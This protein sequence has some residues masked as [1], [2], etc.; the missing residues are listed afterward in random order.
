MAFAIVVGTIVARAV[1]PRRRMR[2]RM[3]RRAR[4]LLSEHPDAE[5][6]SQYMRFESTFE[7]GKLRELDVLIS[8][9]NKE[10]WTYVRIRGASPLLTL[11]SWGGGV[12]VDF[13]Q[14]PS[15]ATKTL[16]T[17]PDSA[18]APSGSVS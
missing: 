6:S 10:G 15:G 12:H 4:Q 7:H 16:H 3:E 11:R 5:R 14:A 8:A 2:Q 18:V 17:N 1:I 13:I 9:M